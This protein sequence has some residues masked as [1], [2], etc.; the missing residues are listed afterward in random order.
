MAKKPKSNTSKPRDRIPSSRPGALRSKASVGSVP[1][2]TSG[3]GT[4]L[5]VFDGPLS[6]G[7]SNLESV[8]RAVNEL[9]PF[10]G[11]LA[12]FSGDLLMDVPPEASHLIMESS[13]PRWLVAL[14]GSQPTLKRA[15]IGWKGLAPERALSGGVVGLD[16]D[17]LSLVPRAA[18]TKEE[19]FTIRHDPDEHLFGLLDHRPTRIDMNLFGM[20]WLEGAADRVAALREIA[21]LDGEAG[22]R[23]EEEEMGVTPD[24][25][26]I[27]RLPTGALS[28]FPAKSTGTKLRVAARAVAA[29]VP[30]EQEP[31][32]WVRSLQT[33]NASARAAL[34][35]LLEAGG[36]RIG[37]V[38]GFTYSLGR[39]AGADL[40]IESHT[41]SLKHASLGIFGEGLYLVDGESKNGTW[42]DSMRIR[43]G[44]AR[45]LK[46][47]TE[48]YF[49]KVS[50]VVRPAPKN[51]KAP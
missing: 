39:G 20:A 51:I 38:P 49:G 2:D 3:A 13:N 9:G 24:G 5:F 27:V 43:P 16:P 6:N 18:V 34:P 44:E 25:E 36:V 48:V 47:R 12:L 26:V 15:L 11:Q 10:P 14:T 17:Q 22:V 23:D 46:E 1:V 8:L 32:L 35:W 19:L 21:D 4:A 50:L 29:K 42:V 40:C 33:Q 37:L 30:L 45:I 28:F 7:A 41:V 31:V